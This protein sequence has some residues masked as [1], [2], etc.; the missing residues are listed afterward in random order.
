MAPFEAL[1]GHRCRSPIGWFEVG[2]T[3]ILGPDLVHQAV[4]KVKLIK[5]RLKLAQSRQKSYADVR[6][7]DIEF[8]VDDWVFL[9][10]TPMKGVMRF[11]RK[12]HPVFHVSMLRKCLG[13]PTQ[14]IPIEGM[15]FSEHL[16][17]EEVLVA[18]LD[19]QVRKLRTKDVASVKVLWRSQN[20]EEA[21]WEAEADM[22]AKY[23]HLFQ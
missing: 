2:E 11:G 21:T 8:Q 20:I 6:R 17:Y 16:S 15:E 5:E 18:I 3:Q 7:R 1:Y 19:R 4:E 12:V 10:V 22:R 14:V 9:K 13:D 23:P